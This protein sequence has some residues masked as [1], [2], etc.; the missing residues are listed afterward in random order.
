MAS[1][2]KLENDVMTK[3]WRRNLDPDDSLFSEVP[4]TNGLSVTG[5]RLAVERGHWVQLNAAGKAVV[6]GFGADAKNAWPVWSGGAGRF[7]AAGGITV[8][9]GDHVAESTGFLASPTNGAYAPGI[10]LTLRDDGNGDAVLDSA[11]SGEFIVAHVE[12]A[13]SGVSAKFPDGL[14][15]IST[16]HAGYEKA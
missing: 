9:Y 16:L 3:V 10:E 5:G 14:L 12:A 7:D 4:G 8:V 1:E 13:P 15:L 2:Y 6:A 11:A